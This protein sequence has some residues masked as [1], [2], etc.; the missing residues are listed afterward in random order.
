MSAHDL[1]KQLGFNLGINVALD[2]DEDNAAQIIFDEKY[3][4]DFE[5]IEETKELFIVSGVAPI[6]PVNKEE[7]YK[8]MLCA[9][10]FGS[11]TRGAVF[12]L[13]DNKDEIILFLKLK[14]E[15]LPYEEFR[16][17]VENFLNNLIEWTIKIEDIAALSENSKGG[18]S[19]EIIGA[20]YIR[21]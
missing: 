10:L 11:A 9:N 7:L 21:I 16:D 14:T 19:N 18:S 1:I 5:Y 12:A 20:N 2:G 4:V 13:D 17:L 8:A 15:N 3:P 6:P